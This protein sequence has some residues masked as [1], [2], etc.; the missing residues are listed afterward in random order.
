[1]TKEQ[2][3]AWIGGDHL[4]VDELLDLLLEIGNGEYGVVAF[5]FDVAQYNKGE[6]ND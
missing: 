3:K 1:M 6:Q 2:L 5:R 4:N